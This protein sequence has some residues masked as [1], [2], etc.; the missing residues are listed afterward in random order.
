MSLRIL[1][2]AIV[3]GATFATESDRIKMDASVLADIPSKRHAALTLFAITGRDSTPA[4]GEKK[5]KYAEALKALIQDLRSAYYWHSEFPKDVDETVA[6]RAFYLTGLHYPASSTMGASYYGDLIQSYTICLYEGE[7]V[8]IAYAVTERFRE[9]DVVIVRGEAQSFAAWKKA[10]D[11]AG[12][13]KG[14]P[15]Q[16]PPSGVGQL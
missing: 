14:R 10:W 3:A 13:V 8:T 11:D 9:Q 15:N 7:V 6:K 4:I 16:Q 1:I 12:E 5:E 2:F